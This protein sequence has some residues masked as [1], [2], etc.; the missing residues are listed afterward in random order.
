M[1]HID[2]GEL[3]SETDD[4]IR[5]GETYV[6]ERNGAIVGYFLPLKVKDTERLR[7]DLEA[8]DRT[9]DA[10]L[11]NGYTRE[12]LA[13]DLDLSKPFRDDPERS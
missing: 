8:L 3:P 6:V 4:E 1:R 12:Q 7:Q 11:Q 2:I 9:I 5:S 10:A 13:D